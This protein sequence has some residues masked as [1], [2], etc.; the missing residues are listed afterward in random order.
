MNKLL[1]PKL[2]VAA[3]ALFLTPA[4]FLAQTPAVRP[5]PS[6]TP[7]ARLSPSPTPLP[8]P[9]TTVQTLAD[10]TG[11]IRSRLAQ[12]QVRRGQVGIK[13]V[14]L[15]S[16][17]TVFEENAEK[18]F[19]PASN[20][21]NFTVATAME[22]LTPDFRFVTSVYAAAMPGPEGTVKGDVRIFGRG[23][24]SISTAFTDGNYYKGLDDLADKI[25]QAGVKRIEG[26]LIGDDT[27]FKGDALPGTWEWDDLQWYY[28]AEVSALPLNDNAVDLS[29]LPGPAGYGC[30][31]KI[32]PLNLLVRVMNQCT[33]GP[34]GS[35]RT[36]TIVKRINQ[37]ILDITGSLPVG[38]SG[39][40]GSVTFTRPADLFV[41]LLK[42]RLALKG[43][44]VT[45][46]AHAVV[47]TRLAAPPPAQV[48]IAK[49]E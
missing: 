36:L 11:K 49:L 23:D 22:K 24:V 35:K 13:I 16:G 18:Y 25:V 37:N 47:P 42:E 43:V 9:S 41:S 33:T 38:D 19:M 21:K 7:A 4:A 46:S 14:S 48:E 45:G 34:A 6:A 30:M 28:G 10:L 5:T 2:T 3:L 20:M 17:R 26:D 1:M 29:V 44:T 40:T 27:Y 15:A 8:S 31:V 39:F 12:P 32:T